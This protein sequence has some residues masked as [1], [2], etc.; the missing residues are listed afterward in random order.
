MLNALSLARRGLGNVSPNP[1]VGCILVSEHETGGR[2]I[3]RGWT[4]P[5]GRPH[6]EA[7]ALRRAGKAAHGA[8]AYIT[9]EPCAHHG[10]TP[11][12]ADALIKAGIARAVIATSDPNPRVSGAGISQLKQSGIN[13]VSKVCQQQADELNKGFFLCAS[14]GRPMF[15]LKVATT[16]DGR[17]ATRTGDSQWITGPEARRTAHRLRAEHDAVL[18]G[19]ETALHDDPLLTCRLP[20]LEERSPLRIIADS[21]LRLPATSKLAETAGDIET[22]VLTTKGE[23][24][25]EN[26]KAALEACRIKVIEIE[27]DPTGRPDVNELSQCL[28]ARGVTRVMIEGGGILAGAFLQQSLIDE[29]A[30]FR[31]PSVAG[32]DALPAIAA[33]GLDRLS[34]T[35]TFLR[36]DAVALGQDILETYYR[37]E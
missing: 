32:G 20:G 11:P 15:T 16:M 33:L 24:G 29:I 27:A 23:G 7:E 30:W 10:Q 34:E 17:I 5:K 37:K 9:L 21:R 1:A 22:W 25:Y 6:A 4:Q 13:V 31:A 12:C 18:I 26:K 36:R 19:V 28:G 35:P 2:V 3:G 14:K 8:S